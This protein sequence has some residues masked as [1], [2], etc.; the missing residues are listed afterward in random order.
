MTKDFAN[1]INDL[2]DSQCD[3]GRSH[4]SFM[5]K[6]GNLVVNGVPNLPEKVFF[7]GLQSFLNEI[8]TKLDGELL[9]AESSHREFVEKLS[10]ISGLPID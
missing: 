2:V 5:A 6:D 3:G 8:A 9:S 1:H 4:L 10:E 7:D